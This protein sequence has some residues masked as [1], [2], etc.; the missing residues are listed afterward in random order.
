MREEITF[1]LSVC[2]PALL[3]A[4]DASVLSEEVAQF[5]G[6]LMDLKRVTALE[7]ARMD[8]SFP[9]FLERFRNLATSVSINDA[10]SAVEIFRVC[11]SIPMRQL[12][13]YSMCL[14][15]SPLLPL[16]TGCVEV[17]KLSSDVITSVC[18]SILSFFKSHSVRNYESVSGPL[19][20]DVSSRSGVS[21][22]WQ[23]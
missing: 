15:E 10:G 23:S 14:N 6:L 3:L 22:C 20:E 1:Y 11:N 19:L 12:F 13:R 8:R 16:A 21:L 18:S 17:A 4:G 5:T 7:K 9:S 2:C